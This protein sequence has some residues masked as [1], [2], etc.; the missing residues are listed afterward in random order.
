MHSPT[1]FSRLRPFQRVAI[2]AALAALA[3][4]GGGGG[5]SA[6]DG[7]SAAP[8]PATPQTGTVTVLLTDGPTDEFCQILATL[9]SIDL[10]GADGRTNIWTGNETVNVLALRNYSDAFAVNSEVPI[11]Q[12][13]KI[14]LTLSELELVRCDEQGEPLPDQSE[15]PRLPGNGKLDLNPREPFTVIGGE[16]LVIEIDMDMNKSIH[17]VKAGNSSRYQFRPVIFVT[18][19]PDDT[20]LVRIFGEA[21]DVED[22]GF[23]LCPLEPA[24]S[25]DDDDDMEDDGE[26]MTDDDDS[27]RCID[28][29]TDAATGIFD[30]NGDP[31]GLPAVQDGGLLTAIGFL[32]RHDDDDDADD[33]DDDLR[34]D[35]VV[36]ELGPQDTFARIAG[37][38]QTVPGNNDIFEFLPSESV[39]PIDV[40]LQGGTRIFSIGSNAELTSA[41]IQPGVAGE[42]DGVFAVDPPSLLKSALIVLEEGASAPDI[43]LTDATIVTVTPA[44]PPTDPQTGR[45]EVNTAELT[46][47]CVKTDADTRILLIT[48]AAGSSETA[49]IAFDDLVVDDV[50]DVFGA[51]DEAEPGCVLADTIQKYAMAP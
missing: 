19:A 42:V 9:T 2:A 10:L 4:C 49:E 13:D 22:P 18:I 44:D 5:S 7:G 16:A 3:A 8:P 14:R 29:V 20:R 45:L 25:M 46:N 11:G 36:L 6:P 38:A 35:A 21:R 43:V 27:G 41:A 12:Y 24:S 50:I 28:V 23:E 33:F 51:D 47:Q 17:I 26:D 31:A 40:L 32:S 39:D 1:A 48:E 15:F 30:E 37:T 34:L